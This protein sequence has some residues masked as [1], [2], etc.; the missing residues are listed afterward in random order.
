MPGTKRAGKPALDEL[1]KFTGVLVMKKGLTVQ[2]QIVDVQ[3][4]PIANATVALGQLPAAYTAN[5]PQ[6]RHRALRPPALPRGR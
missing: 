2:G 4:K 1:L 5:R 6:R 3:D